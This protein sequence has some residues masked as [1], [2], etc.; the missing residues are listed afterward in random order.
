MERWWLSKFQLCWTISCFLSYFF[1]LSSTP[2][3]LSESVGR[4]RAGTVFVLWSLYSSCSGAA[5]LSRVPLWGRRDTEE[6]EGPSVTSVLWTL[7]STGNYGSATMC[8]KH[9]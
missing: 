7:C 6:A 8:V 9:M 1:L 4:F 5:G 2:F 3:S